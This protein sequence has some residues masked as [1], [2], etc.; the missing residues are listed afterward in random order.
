VS[1]DSSGVGSR[2]RNGHL[3]G[4]GAIEC[5]GRWIA[6]HIDL[7]E[8]RIVDVGAN[9][10]A[11]SD[12]FWR[13]AAG[14][15]SVLSVEPLAENVARIRKRIEDLG[16]TNWRVEP[17]AVSGRQGSVGLKV[18]VDANGYANCVVIPTGGARAV[19]ARRLSKLAPDATLV[20]ID[21][22][23]HEYAVI[24]EALGRLH[25]ARAWAVEL[26]CVPDR[27]LQRV[28]GQF[29]AEGYRVYAAARSRVDADNPS[30]EW[31]SIE[32]SP[33]LDWSEVPPARTHVDGRAFRM[34]HV[35]AVR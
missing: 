30:A 2:D 26:H 9:V 14:T 5:Q 3:A 35:M 25:E 24:D 31:Q 10:G 13:A 11:L 22:E 15:S 28:L 23:G 29:M 18:A 33:L 32:V 1:A 12:F 21:I 20:K 27:P 34:L 16:A 8:Q 6:S 17:C 19:A 4:Q 7:R